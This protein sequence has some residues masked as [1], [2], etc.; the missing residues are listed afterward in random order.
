M[1]NHSITVV[2]MTLLFTCSGAARSLPLS[3]KR[4]GEFLSPYQAAGVVLEAASKP[5]SSVILLTDGRNSPFSESD[6]IRQLVATWSVGVFEVAVDGHD[7]NVTQ[8]Q[9]S[10]VV[11][12]ARRVGI[13]HITTEAGR[14]LSHHY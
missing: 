13:S 5:C 3:T 1:T 9:L 8:A 2:L 4:N 10:L 7:A 14:S 11:D 6:G 12:A